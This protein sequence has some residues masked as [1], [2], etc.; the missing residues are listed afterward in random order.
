MGS[1]AGGSDWDELPERESFEAFKPRPA[2]AAPAVPDEDEAPI[3]LVAAPG[4]KPRLDAI[5]AFDTTGSMTPWIENVQEKM[6]YLSR[7]LLELL[8]I[9]IRFIGVGDHCDGRLMLQIKPPAADAAALARHIAE[10]APTDGGDT[11]EALECLFKVLNALAVEVPTVLV[12]ITDSIPHGMAGYTGG[13]DGCPFGVDWGEEL[14][15]LRGKLRKIYLV[16]CAEDAEIVALQR[17]MVGDN[18]LIRLADLRRLVNLLMAICMDEA[19]ELDYFMDV[20]ERQR[21]RERRL[22]VLRLLGRAS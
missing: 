10:L 21:G 4:R 18:G 17:Q 13:D 19:G 20:L 2:A 22:E 12:V 7:G 9:E 6:A 3:D 11:P 8:D 1:Y 16:S 14:D 15:E 5:F